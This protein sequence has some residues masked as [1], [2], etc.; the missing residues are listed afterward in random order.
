MSVCLQ[1]KD[2]KTASVK[3]TQFFLLTTSE[4]CQL[5]PHQELV[6]L[7]DC[8]SRTFSLAPE[9]VFPLETWGF[10]AKPE[11][12]QAQTKIMALVTFRM[13]KDTTGP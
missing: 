3:H 9:S 1:N 7:T 8:T 6:F 13:A 10:Q 5:F 2:G 12:F 4:T 11:V